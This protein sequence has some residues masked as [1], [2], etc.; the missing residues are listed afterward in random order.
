MTVDLLTNRL[1]F[2]IKSI[3]AMRHAYGE[4][5]KQLNLNV[6]CPM[7]GLLG[8]E[9]AVVAEAPGETE[10]VKKLPLIGPS[11][12]VLW[13]TLRRFKLTRMD[14]YITNVCKRQVSFGSD[15]R[16]PINKHEQQAWNDL[17]SWELSQLP[18]LK[19]VVA[20]GNFALTALC[21]KTGITDW[22]GSVLTVPLRD[23]RLVQVICTFNPAMILREPKTEITF[24][25]DCAKIRRVLDGKH[26]PKPITTLTNPHYDQVLDY[27][28]DVRKEAVH[29]TPVSFDIEMIGQATACIGFANNAEQAICVAY[30]DLDGHKYSVAHEREIRKAIQ[31]LLLDPQVKLIGQNANFDSYYLWYND[32]IRVQPVWF[33]TMLAHHTLYSTLPHN[34]GFLTTQYTDHPYYKDELNAW[35]EDGDVERFWEYNGRDC[36]VTWQVSGKLHAELKRDKLEEFFFSHVMRLQPHLVRMTVAGIKMDTRLKEQIRKDLFDDLNTK[37]MEF[38]RAVREATGDDDYRPNPKSHDQ[39]STLFFKRLRLVGRGTSTDAENRKRIL[40]HPR[41]SEASKRVVL[42][43]NDYATEQKFFSTYVEMRLDEDGRARCEY[44]QT[45]VQSAPGRLSSAKVLWGSGMNLQN[46]PSRAHPMFVADE[47]C[48]LGYFDMSQAEARI[49]AYEAGIERWKEQF[50][51]ARIDGSYDAHRAL[52]SDMFHVPY[53]DVPADDREPGTHAVTLRFIAKRCRHGLNYRMAADR[54]A[55]TTGLSPTEAA[56]AYNL[57]H[58]ETPELRKWW[59]VLEREVRA[60]KML[61][62]CFGRR[63]I[64]LERLTTEALESIVAFKPQS[65]CGDHVC[66]VMYQSE[67]DDRWPHDARLWLNNHDALICLAPHAKVKHCLSIMKAYAEMPLYIRGEQLVIPADTKISVADDTGTHRW[68]TLTKHKIEAAVLPQSQRKLA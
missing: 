55:T 34:L 47:G 46:Q 2:P 17:L 37:L 22:R 53:D 9:I 59:E 15:K 21:G 25:L 58:R 67:S 6:D 62:N 39:L 42:A 3:A 16:H 64:I 68:S 49:V 19:Y 36:C 50:E 20:L 28:R 45:G 35:R 10:V 41:T 63:L 4:K 38:H 14:T 7:D 30:R 43:L 8:A 51:R 56:R 40:A 65:A 54:L 66:R 11:G 13:S 52:A 61:F 33:D 29:G 5:A 60:S 27:I 57:Y 12:Q 32:H 1:E 31:T 48:S 23:G 18:N 44:K 24:N 26:N